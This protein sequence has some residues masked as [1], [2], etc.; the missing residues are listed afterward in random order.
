MAGR[1]VES[2][3]YSNDDSY[4]LVRESVERMKEIISAELTSVG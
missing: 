3:E 4:K 2:N 1:L